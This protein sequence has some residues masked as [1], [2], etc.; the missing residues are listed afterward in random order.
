MTPQETLAPLAP[1]GTHRVGPAE[2]SPPAG[3]GSARGASGWTSQGARLSFALL[4]VFAVTYFGTAVLTSAAFRDVAAL[5]V[6][7]APL[8][9]LLG[10]VVFIVGIAVTRIHLVRGEH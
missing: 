4:A 7:G 8:A 9:F 5:R 2:D 3:P 1:D 6:A 10:L